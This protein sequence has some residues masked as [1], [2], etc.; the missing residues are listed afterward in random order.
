MQQNGDALYLLSDHT[1]SY[2]GVP[3]KHHSLAHTQPVSLA[4]PTKPISFALPYSRAGKHKNWVSLQGPK[5]LSDSELLTSVVKF[6]A[7]LPLFK[8]LEER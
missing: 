3:Y 7:F 2:A 4:S 5:M 1:A 6:A 8:E